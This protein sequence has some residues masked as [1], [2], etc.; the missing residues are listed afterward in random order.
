LALYNGQSLVS[1]LLVD[2]SSLFVVLLRVGHAC[3]LP[4]LQ[5]D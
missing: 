4:L 5:I 2:Y 3:M 1:S